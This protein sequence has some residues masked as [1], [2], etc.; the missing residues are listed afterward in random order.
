[1]DPPRSSF[2]LSFLNCTFKCTHVNCTTFYSGTQLRKHSQDED[3]KDLHLPEA[4][5]SVLPIS[6]PAALLS[7]TLKSFWLP[8]NFLQVKMVHTLPCLAS[9]KRFVC[10]TQPCF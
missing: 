8:P 6:L 5:L 10:E 2:C 7:I 4:S 3:I 9:F 1:M